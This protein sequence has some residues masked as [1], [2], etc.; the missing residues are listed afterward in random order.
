MAEF[1]VYRTSAS[2][3]RAVARIEAVTAEDACRIVRPT[4]TLAPGETLTAELAEI[5]DAKE[6]ERNRT[7]RDLARDTRGGEGPTPEA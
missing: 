7:S 2:E 5:A 6:V 1:I 4:V 3:Q